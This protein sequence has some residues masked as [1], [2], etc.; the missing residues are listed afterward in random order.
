MIWMHLQLNCLHCYKY[1]CKSIKNL[2][3]SSY[4][5]GDFNIDLLK[6]KENR[7]YCK[8]ADEIISHGLFLKITL[9]TRI[10]ESSSTLIDNIVTDNIDEVGTSGVAAGQNLSVSWQTDSSMLSVTT[11]DTKA[12]VGFFRF[13]MKTG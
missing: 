13:I 5:C 7:H 8:Y 11:D 1:Y 3:P 6:V 12:Y 2:K 9:P 4:V 10:C